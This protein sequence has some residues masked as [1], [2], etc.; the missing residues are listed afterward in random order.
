MYKDH[1]GLRN[2]CLYKDLT[3]ENKDHV[4]GGLAK[5]G[6]IRAPCNSYLVKTSVSA[7]TK[8][9]VTLRFFCV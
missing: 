9:L 5:N 1:V 3:I 8:I 6:P 7:V 2:I 4:C